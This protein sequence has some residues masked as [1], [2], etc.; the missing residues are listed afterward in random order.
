MVDKED[1]HLQRMGLTKLTKDDTFVEHEEEWRERSHLQNALKA[2]N[3]VEKK[4]AGNFFEISATP[5]DKVYVS[6][7]LAV[8]VLVINAETLLG[9]VKIELE[10]EHDWAMEEAAEWNKEYLT[11]DEVKHKEKYSSFR[12]ASDPETYSVPNYY[13]YIPANVRNAE[14]KYKTKFLQRNIEENEWLTLENIKVTYRTLKCN[15]PLISDQKIQHHYKKVHLLP[16][17]MLNF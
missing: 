2:S 8:P 17:K 7:H 5:E 14:E 16:C 3:L 1:A 9:G 15:L 11:F 13:E 4:P 6:C 10:H 12:Y